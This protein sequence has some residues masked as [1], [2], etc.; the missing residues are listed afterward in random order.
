MRAVP[1]AF[2]TGDGRGD[3]R[4]LT[5]GVEGVQRIC[6]ILASAKYITGAMEMWGED[7]VSFFSRMLTSTGTDIM[8]CC[9]SFSLSYGPKSTVELTCVLSGVYSIIAQS[10][11]SRGRT[12]G[13]HDF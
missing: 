2:G 4:K 5:A 9:N 11:G 1:A 8:V 3:W 7:L 12:T 10:E 6:K 13:G